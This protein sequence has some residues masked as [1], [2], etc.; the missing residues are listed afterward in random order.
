MLLIID[1]MIV[2]LVLNTENMIEPIFQSRTLW[3]NNIFHLRTGNEFDHQARLHWQAI[4]LM[5]IAQFI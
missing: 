2:L 1:G 4:F 3:P 5:Q